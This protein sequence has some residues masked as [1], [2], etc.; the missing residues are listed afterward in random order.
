MDV[1]EVLFVA[2]DVA[3]VEVEDV[4]EVVRDDIAEQIAETAGGLR[5]GAELL[6]GAAIN[7]SLTDDGCTPGDEKGCTTG[8][9][10]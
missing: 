6:I 9:T 8:A 2:G 5:G 1:T 10:I 7:R 3:G 4:V